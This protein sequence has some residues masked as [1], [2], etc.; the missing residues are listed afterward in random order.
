MMLA[1]LPNYGFGIPFLKVLTTVN[2][3]TSPSVSNDPAWK[4]PNLAF[5]SL[6]LTSAVISAIQYAIALLNLKTTKNVSDR[7]LVSRSWFIASIAIFATS[8]IMVFPSFFHKPTRDEGLFATLFLIRDDHRV[9]FILTSL[10][11]ALLYFIPIITQLLSRLK[12][13]RNSICLTLSFSFVVLIASIG[14]VVIACVMVGVSIK[15]RGLHEL[16]PNPA[17]ASSKPGEDAI[18]VTIVCCVLT[19]YYST[20]VSV[21]TFFSFRATRK[22][23]RR[24]RRTT[25]SQNSDQQVTSQPDPSTIP[26]SAQYLSNSQHHSLA[27]QTSSKVYRSASSPLYP[28]GRIGKSD[29]INSDWMDSS[30]QS[31][32][33]EHMTM[34]YSL[35]EGEEQTWAKKYGG[36]PTLSSSIQVRYP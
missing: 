4:I 16:V 22:S 3:K 18:I 21:M 27:M 25:S 5:V 19:L 31:E 12:C 9:E 10:L 20:Y 24:L 35:T 6:N 26:I 34:A 36:T 14:Q 23:I 32:Q 2:D 1:L 28:R 7:Y 33:H 15:Y 11:H 29:S 13:V 17:S 30:D 8:F